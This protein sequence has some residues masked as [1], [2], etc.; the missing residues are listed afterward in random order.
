MLDYVVLLSPPPEEECHLDVDELL[1]GVC[2]Q[3]RDD[4]VQ[5]VLDAHR[6]DVPVQERMTNF[7]YN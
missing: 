4:R 3:L 2:V 5:D 1:A 6:S 7:D